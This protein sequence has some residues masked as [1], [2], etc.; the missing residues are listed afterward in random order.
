MTVVFEASVLAGR[1]IR[2]FLRSPQLL[3][4]ALAFP[5][6]LLV[7]LY[8]MFQEVVGGA[9]DE[10]YI[11]RLTPGIA[12]FSVAYSCTGTA[13]GFYGDLRGGF[14][15]RLRTL[16]IG[17]SAGLLG[18]ITGDLV[19]FVLV[20]AVTVLVGCLLG[21]RFE[22]GPVAAVGFLLVVV[23]FASIFL[24][25]AVVTA[26]S[27]GSQETASGLLNAPVTLLLLLSTTLVPAEAFPGFVQPVVRANPLSCAHG[28]LMGLSSGG[29]VLV[30]VLQTLAWVVAATAVLA[31]LAVRLGR[32]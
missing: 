13:V 18:R 26:L 28:A 15:D 17:R 1:N 19:K 21:F 25:L 32:R 24:W 16:P 31:P 14:Q 10:P 29:P 3:G 20:T 6:I 8:V 22:R 23:A 9:G 4:D 7:A 11:A 30:P 2:R 5:L 27:A 12:L